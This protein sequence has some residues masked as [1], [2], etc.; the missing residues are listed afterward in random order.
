[1]NFNDSIINNIAHTC[2]NIQVKKDHQLLLHKLTQIIPGLA[3]DHILTR[4]GWH[5]TGGVL[6]RKGVHISNKL[7]DWVERVSTGDLSKLIG[8]YADSGYIVTSLIGKTHYFVAKT[9]ETAQD[10]VQLEV[11]ELQEVQDHALFSN[12]VLADDIEDVTDPSDIEKLQPEPVGEPHY[13]FRRITSI[14]DFVQ[15]M[16]KRM[17]ERGNKYNPLQR[18]MQDWDR[19]SSKETGA[20]CYHWILML[21]KYTDVWGEP[22]MQAKPVSTLTKKLPLIKLNGIHGGSRLATLI[23]GFDHDAGYP[24]AW[25]FYMLS[26]TEVPHKLAEAIHDDRVGAYDYLPVRDV[27]VL[28]E[29]YLKPYGI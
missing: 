10:F 5:R 22:V 29:W 17:L 15:T 9:G 8:R 1:M 12:E 11:E 13:L 14:A 28:N 18:F 19:S 3:F 7:H 21:Q 4:G 23:H 27:K 2:A 20:F 26:H 6:D 16:S 25:Y 24:M